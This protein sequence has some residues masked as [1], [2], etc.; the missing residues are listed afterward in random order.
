MMQ[1]FTNITLGTGSSPHHPSTSDTDHGTSIYESL[2]SNGMVKTIQTGQGESVLTQDIVARG[3]EMMAQKLDEKHLV[4]LLTPFIEGIVRE[5][6]PFSISL[7]NSEEYPWLLAP[8][9]YDKCKQKPDLFLCARSLVEFKRPPN[10]AVDTSRIF[11]IFPCWNARSSLWCIMDAKW[12]LDMNA[13]GEK[14]KYIQSAG[15]NCNIWPRVAQPLKLLLFDVNEFWMIVGIG[16]VIT[17]VTHC[18]WVVPGSRQLLKEFLMTYDPWMVATQLLLQSLQ[19]QLSDQPILGAGAHGR[20]FL[21]TDG[22]VLKV[23]AGPQASVL[24]TEFLKILN[25]Q[26]NNLTREFVIPVEEDSFRYGFVNC[27]ESG[28]RSDYEYAGYILKYKGDNINLKQYKKLSQNVDIKNRLVEFL[29]RFHQLNYIHG[30]P[31][32]DNILLVN[33]DLKFIDLRVSQ[34][35]S[36]TAKVH[37]FVLLFNSI[38][39]VNKEII[40]PIINKIL[41]PPSSGEDK[42]NGDKLSQLTHQLHLFMGIIPHQDNENDKK[43]GGNET[44]GEGKN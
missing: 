31:R 19:V 24:E 34:Y 23:S 8:S 35:T 33:G 3:N 40:T 21:L 37:D 9:K 27:S 12:R 17:K 26:T 2:L 1:L 39:E 5:I 25:H 11:G 29:Y 43:S 38:T 15:F 7:V 18:G 30:D 32:L 42:I 44:K 4:A 22:R 36:V 20:A 10:N 16:T 13:F 41:N 28:H 14:I 6:D